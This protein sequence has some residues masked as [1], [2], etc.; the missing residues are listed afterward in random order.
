[1]KPLKVTMTTGQPAAGAGF[2]RKLTDLIAQSRANALGNVLRRSAARHHAKTALVDGERSFSYAEFDV[3]VDAVAAS[4]QRDGIGAGMRV[5]LLS[6]NCWEF[7]ALAW[8]C[9]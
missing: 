6:R 3:V 2:D 7:A 8:G 9:G 1:L 4:L 5:G